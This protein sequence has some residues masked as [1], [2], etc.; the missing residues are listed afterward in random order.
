MEKVYWDNIETHVNKLFA[1]NEHA[2]LVYHNLQHTTQV[3][4]RAMEIGQHYTLSEEQ[5]FVLFAAAWFHD[6]GHLFAAWEL[7]E[8]KSVELM[9]QYF[10]ATDVPAALVEQIATCI[11]AT[12]MP[13]H[14]ASLLEEIICDA[15]L[16]HLGTEKFWETDG[17]VKQEVELRTGKS[18]PQWASKACSFLESHRYFTSYC[19]ELLGNAKT[20]NVERMQQLRG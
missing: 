16:Y 4:S 17:L 19:N 5:L 13:A 10:S 7:H 9:R 8:E 3:V 20:H 18:F 14:P 12:K 2:H 6:T 15:D 1:A 11:M